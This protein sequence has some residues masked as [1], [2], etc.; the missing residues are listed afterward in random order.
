[1]L[2]CSDCTHWLFSKIYQRPA[3]S[4]PCLGNHWMGFKRVAG[5]RNRGIQPRPAGRPWL[6]KKLREI[7]VHLRDGA[8]G[9]DILQSKLFSVNKHRKERERRGDLPETMAAGEAAR[10]P[11]REQRDDGIVRMEGEE[12]KKACC[13]EKIFIERD[14]CWERE[15]NEEMKG[16]GKVGGL[17]GC[18]PVVVGAG[19][20][21]CVLGL[22]KPL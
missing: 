9:A 14:E 18:L 5:G 21:A 12:K 13:G 8:T 6:V 11:G 16:E 20:R 2:I 10:S 17:P 19:G 22:T 4:I 1:M 7:I 3:Q 15:K